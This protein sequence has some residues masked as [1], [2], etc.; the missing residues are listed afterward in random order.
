MSVLSY[1]EVYK[2]VCSV[3]FL[4]TTHRQTGGSEGDPLPQGLTSWEV[5]QYVAETRLIVTH[6]S[7]CTHTQKIYTQSRY[8]K[9]LTH[10]LEY[11]V[12]WYLCESHC[13][14]LSLKTGSFLINLLTPPQLPLP[15]F[16]SILPTGVPHTPA[17][18]YSSFPLILF[19]LPVS[20]LPIISPH[21]IGPGRKQ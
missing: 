17:S 19:F 15:F 12:S 7:I 4:I 13:C 16:L 11:S 5:L 18:F 9:S 2:R 21:N 8:Y 14:R 20:L 10:T 6:T 3:L 1:A